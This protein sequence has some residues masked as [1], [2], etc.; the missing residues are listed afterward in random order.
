[1]GANY[2]NILT[3]TEAAA[4]GDD[5]GPVLMN[6]ILHNFLQMFFIYKLKVF[7]KH[8]NVGQTPKEVVSLQLTIIRMLKLKLQQSCC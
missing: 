2:I 4:L 5:R 8:G 6:Y 3:A 1:M 7:F